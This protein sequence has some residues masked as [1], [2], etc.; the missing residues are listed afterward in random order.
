[1]HPLARVILFGQTRN[2]DVSRVSRLTFFRI[3]RAAALVFVGFATPVV[4]QDSAWIQVEA[5]PR[6]ETAQ[7]RAE[8]YGGQDLPL[9]GYQLGTS[10]WFALVVGPFAPDQAEAELSRLIGEDLIPR[11]SFLSDGATFEAQF[12]PRAG[13]T[14]GGATVNGTADS[15]T[16]ED[17]EISLLD[18]AEPVGAEEP[19]AGAIVSTDISQAGEVAPDTA[20]AAVEAQI[21]EEPAEGTAESELA[22]AIEAQE[23]Q[24]AVEAAEAEA[25]ETAALAAEQAA[26]VAAAQAEAEA[27][28][29]AAA[30]AAAQA[31]A[32][33]AA[34]AEIAAAAEAEVAAQAAANAAAAESAGDDTATGTESAQVA[35]L[36]PPSPPVPDETVEE[37][38]ASEA[39]LT[40]PAK[41]LLQTALKWEGYYD[42][43]I[44]GAYGRITR[45]AMSAWQE[46]KGIEPTGVLTTAQR[47][48]LISDY[49]AILDGL[50]LAPVTDA[51]AGITVNLPT[52]L[53]KFDRYV[54][55]FAHYEPIAE[56]DPTRVILISQTGDQAELFGL[57]DIMQTL[58][59]VPPEGLRDRGNS[60]FRLEGQDSRIISETY[61]E[62]RDGQI[63][64]YTLIW[65]I[66]DEKRRLR[67]LENMRASFTR[68]EG[69]LPDVTGDDQSIDLVSGLKIRRP[70]LARSGFYV[71]SA[72][73]VLTTTEAVDACTRITLDS[74]TDATIATRDADLGLALLTPA[75]P[76]S[77]TRVARFR[78]GAPRLQS[79][80]SV[81]GYSYGGVLGTPTMT[82]GQLADVRGLDGNDTLN[83]LALATQPGD[84]GG[85]VFD[86]AG[87]VI[88]MLV[89]TNS[90][91]GQQLPP[92]VSFATDAP[93]I[94][95][96]LSN[97]GSN[98][99]AANEDAPIPPEDLTRQAIGMTV[100]VSCWK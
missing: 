86:N 27:A 2:L 60:S 81:A 25:A 70:A 6:A 48:R 37:A 88:G 84:A 50:D 16:P 41:E 100:L 47:G 80:V 32:E 15:A 85:P 97:A 58:E 43:G 1:V 14:A 35:P 29:R 59:I 65:P 66:G 83:R 11:D 8:T 9:A 76:L 54:P 24:L 92:N 98:T 36:D 5:Y 72:G 34:I 28:D 95:T 12:W 55:P 17:V 99:A 77:P 75:S 40:K 19:A 57:Y 22:A 56:G 30:Q 26:A 90:A 69:A 64:G 23:Q 52:A 38:R 79:E 73:S 18:D 33:A 42:G 21:N 31:E 71:D 4:A 91:T 68:L 3:F 78:P 61:A 20:E 45:R 96:F 10:G 46:S 93:A 53:V 39:E 7:A 49:N 67:V 51:R 87:A 44:D 62:L 13:V 89:P 74:E 63:K 82:F 94:A